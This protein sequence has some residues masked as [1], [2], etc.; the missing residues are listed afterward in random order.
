MEPSGLKINK[1]D[2]GGDSSDAENN[3]NDDDVKDL[4]DALCQNDEFSGPIDLS[5]NDLSQLVSYINIFILYFILVCPL[6]SRGNRQTWIQK[7]YKIK[8]GQE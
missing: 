6:S 7:H 1:L 4:V 5:N 2:Y 3:L 8:F